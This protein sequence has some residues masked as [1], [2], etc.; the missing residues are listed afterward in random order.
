VIDEGDIPS[1]QC[2]MS[3]REPESVRKIDGLS[4]I[5]INFY[6]PALTPRLSSTET[7]LQL[8]EN[9]TLFAVCFVC[10]IGKFLDSYCCNPLSGRGEGRPRSH[11]WKP[12]ASVC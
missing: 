12:I 2:K 8:S 9:I 3:L 5:F 1:I 11:F 6:V 7:L 4:P 10:A